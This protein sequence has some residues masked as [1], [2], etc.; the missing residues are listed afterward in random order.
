[1][2]LNYRTFRVASSLINSE[3]GR[4]DFLEITKAYGRKIR[5]I[6]IASKIS[7]HWHEGHLMIYSFGIGFMGGGWIR[8][9]HLE[10]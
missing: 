3:R 1:M 4:W 8:Y 5:K 7:L 10:P 2:I 9:I 6:F